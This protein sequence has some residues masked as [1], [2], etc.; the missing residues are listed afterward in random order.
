MGR[1]EFSLPNAQA[2]KLTC[3]DS[4]APNSYRTILNKLLLKAK[5]SLSLFLWVFDT[6]AGGS[7]RY[8]LNFYANKSSEKQCAAPLLL[9]FLSTW[10]WKTAR[11]N[12]SGN[13]IASLN[14]GNSPIVNCWENGQAL[15]EFTASRVQNTNNNIRFPFMLCTSHKQ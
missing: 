2:D 5:C 4:F 8:L 1:F 10:L 3:R 12:F 11:S 13:F 9:L 15:E 6:L 14:F 7:I